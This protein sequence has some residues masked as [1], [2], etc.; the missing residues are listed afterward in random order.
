MSPILSIKCEYVIHDEREAMN[1]YN[2]IVII[3]L[4]VIYNWKH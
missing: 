4:I 3:I 2:L 1:A